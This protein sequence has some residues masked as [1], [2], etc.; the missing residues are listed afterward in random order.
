M[1]TLPG[2]RCLRP[3]SRPVSLTARDA[4]VFGDLH[5]HR[6]LS[7]PWLARVRFGGSQ[8]A[9][10]ERLRKLSAAGYVERLPTVQ[11]EFKGYR[12]TTTG[13]RAG[14][15]DGRARRR[16]P[17]VGAVP[18]L[19]AMTV[20]ELADRLLRALPEGA[21]FALAWVTEQELLD[22]LAADWF[23]AD[24]GAFLPDGVLEAS[25]SATGEV[26]RMAVEVELHRK[27]DRAYAAKLAWYRRLLEREVF[28]RLR[29][30]VAD[31]T[32]GT[33][34]RRALR[35]AGFSVGDPRVEV[36]PLPPEVPVY[37]RRDRAGAA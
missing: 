34:V 35:A 1:D 11:G 3:R 30:Y 18:V 4:R 25:A 12:L 2:V 21:P 24:A 20:A 9:A 28:R 5:R 8:R 27:V 31:A 33:T 36:K 16:G 26:S 17:G 19:H 15:L 22:G 37:G 14:G 13:R 10:W 6:V 29:W 32:T 23:P 7:T